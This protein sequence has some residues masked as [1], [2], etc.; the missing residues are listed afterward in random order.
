MAR[1]LLRL[2]TRRGQVLHAAAQADG[3]CHQGRE[4]GMGRG[5]VLHAAA[6]AD[7]CY[8]QGTEAGVGRRQVLHTAVQADSCCHQGTEAGVG[9]GQ[10]LHA[11]AQADGR[12]H[13]GTE[14]GMWRGP[15]PPEGSPGPDQWAALARALEP[16]RTQPHLF[17]QPEAERAGGLGEQARIHHFSL[18]LTTITL[19]TIG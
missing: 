2:P 14:A 10:V 6:Q 3:R 5:Q 13:Q 4:A 16:R 17:P 19:M 7:G 1:R 18:H 11:A 15:L 9:R 8:H 12:S